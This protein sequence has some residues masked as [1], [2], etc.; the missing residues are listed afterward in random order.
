[1][2]VDIEKLRAEKE[3]LGEN[4]KKLDMERLRKYLDESNRVK[5]LQVH[6]NYR[7]CKSFSRPAFF[8]QVS[9]HLLEVYQTFP[10]KSMERS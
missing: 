6:I 2:R 10:S 3:C 8:H 9:L 7:D 1:M 5:S 4:C